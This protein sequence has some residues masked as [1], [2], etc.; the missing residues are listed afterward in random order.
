[1]KKPAIILINLGTPNS[2]E[3]KDVGI[4][5]KE[6]L[7]DPQVID[8]PWLFR[9]FLV[10]LIIVPK[11]SKES[12][13]LYKN[14]WTENGS[15]LLYNCQKLFKSFQE[16]MKDRDIELAMRYG[17]PSLSS[18]IEKLHSKGNTEIDLLPLYPQ[19]A[20]SSVETVLDKC[21]QEAR[22][23][24]FNGQMRYY[25][26]FYFHEAYIKVLA[27]TIIETLS[28]K[29]PDFLLYSY[30]GLP[31]HQVAATGTACE[32][33]SSCCDTFESHS[34]SCYR[35]Q[36]YRTSKLVE[37]Y[38][39]SF[40]IPSQVAFQSRLGSRPW[41]KPYTDQVV[42]DLAKSG[43]K[44][45]AVACPAFTADCLETLEEI[46]IRIAEDFK[47]A[48]GE[49]V[50]LVPSLNDRP[51]WVAALKTLTEEVSLVDLPS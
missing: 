47:E 32:F 17:T 40:N 5:L 13:E 9:W 39:K 38:L 21:R 36:C 34:P 19:Y 45:L 50:F 3:P 41:L 2:P 37:P 12:S 14:I 26:E 49:E 4:Y 46:E 24:G 30:H 18:A 25:K 48:G 1:M 16:I 27:D 11:R 44:R 10:N 29:K 43:V 28:E 15:P 51:D 20:T 42:K 35:A 31:E 23:I 33:K 22:N 6:F 8:I 7:M